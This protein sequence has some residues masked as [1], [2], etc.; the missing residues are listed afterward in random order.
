MAARAQKVKIF[1]EQE[2]NKSTGMKKSYQQFWN[3]KAEELCKSN[4]L[5]TFK[6]GEIQ[7]TINVAWTLKRA[8][9]LKGEV[10][11]V[12]NEVATKFSTDKHL[13][14]SLQCIAQQK[15]E[16]DT[17]ASE[18]LEMFVLNVFSLPLVC[19]HPFDDVK[20]L[21]CLTSRQ[22]RHKSRWLTA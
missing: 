9:I 8:D 13:H 17:F 19:Y 3:D 4:T 14:I 16:I 22:T 2:I 18:D 12:N 11:E 6:P 21:Q 20:S 5:K 15:L 1:S 7:G 10:E